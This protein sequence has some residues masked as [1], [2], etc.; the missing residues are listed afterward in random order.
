MYGKLSL[1]TIYK[2]DGERDRPV[3]SCTSTVGS[4]NNHTANAL[5]ATNEQLSTLSLENILM[6]IGHV[7]LCNQIKTFDIRIDRNNISQ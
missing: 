3:V 4:N 5:R 6:E 1:K 2:S 7:L